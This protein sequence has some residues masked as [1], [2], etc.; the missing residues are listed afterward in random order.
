MYVGSGTGTDAWQA[1]GGISG[2]ADELEEEDIFGSVYLDSYRGGGTKMTVTWEPL[3]RLTP[4]F[5]TV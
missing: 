4:N 1:M 2:E 5:D 3:A